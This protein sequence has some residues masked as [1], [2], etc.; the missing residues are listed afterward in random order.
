MPM[1]IDSMIDDLQAWRSYPVIGVDMPI[2]FAYYDKDDKF[3]VVELGGMVEMAEDPLMQ[4]G[5]F[6]ALAS[7]DD[8]HRIVDEMH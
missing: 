2:R 5:H 6:M 7:A 3:Q 1:T 8:L 4:K